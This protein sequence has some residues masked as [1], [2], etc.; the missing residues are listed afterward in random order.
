MSQHF[1][2][3]SFIKLKLNKKYIYTYLIAWERN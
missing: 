3:N 2:I 1:S